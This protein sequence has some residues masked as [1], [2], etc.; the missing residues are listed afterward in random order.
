MKKFKLLISK[1]IYLPM[2]N[3]DTDQIIPARFLK[4]ITRDGLA[5]NLFIDWRYGMDHCLKKKLFL[6]N[7]LYSG[8]ILITGSNFGCGSSREHAIWALFDYGFRVIISSFFA[9]IFKENAIN[10][11]LLPIEITP[12]FLEIILN[13]IKNNRNTQFK[14]DLDKQILNIIGENTNEKFIIDSYKKKCLLNGWD[15]IDY[16]VSKK[17]EIEDFEIKHLNF[18]I[19]IYK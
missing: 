5:E 17:K 16:L 6:N 1:A 3:I 4:S 11:G 13:K 14:V 15:D 7:T 18:F 2:V 10:N 12:Q 8:K 9:S 19:S